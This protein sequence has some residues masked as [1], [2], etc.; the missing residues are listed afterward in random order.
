MPMYN[1][2]KNMQKNSAW[3]ISV[4]FCIEQYAQYVIYVEILQLHIE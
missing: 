3:S 1:M 4:T 2:P